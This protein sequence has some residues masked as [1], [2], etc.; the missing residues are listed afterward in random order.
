MIPS[1]IACE[2]LYLGGYIGADDALRRG[3]LNRVVP[4]RQALRKAMRLADAICGNAP[5]SLRRM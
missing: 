2:M 1:G 4:R 3:L 5:V